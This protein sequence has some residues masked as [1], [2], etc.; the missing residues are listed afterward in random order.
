MASVPIQSERKKTNGGVESDHFLTPRAHLR[1]ELQ[2]VHDLGAVLALIR[3]KGSVA[4][5]AD[6]AKAASW[7]DTE[8]AYF[9]MPLAGQDLGEIDLLVANGRLF[10]RVVRQ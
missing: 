2:A 9:D 4:N 10:L 1:V 3:E 5:R 8:Y 7:S 6:S